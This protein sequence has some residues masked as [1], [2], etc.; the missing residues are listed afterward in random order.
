MAN[1]F[2]KLR[3]QS[4]SSIHPPWQT[5]QYVTYVLE[6]DEGGWVACALRLLGRAEDGVWIMSGDFKTPSG[7]ATVWFRCDPN[8]PSN[9]PD[10]VPVK[11]EKIRMSPVDTDDPR[12]LLQDPTLVFSVAMNMLLVR[13][14][15]AAL[16]CLKRPARAVSYPC[17]IDQVYPFI[18]EGP[19]YQKHHDLNPRVPLTGVACLSIDG[20]KNPMTVASFGICDPKTDVNSYE[21][22]VDLSHPTPVE[23]DGFSLTYPS[24]WFL[25]PRSEGQERDAGQPSYFL[26]AGGNSCM[27]TLSVSLERGSA[28]HIAHERANLRARHSTVAEGGMGRLLPRQEVHFELEGNAQGFISD[29]ENSGIAGFAY[30]G[31]YCAD[32]GDRLAHVNVFGCASKPNPRLATTLTAM[33]PAFRAILESF[34]FL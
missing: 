17:G 11:I 20:G 26:M 30:S 15:S 5:G 3:G 13:R 9:E 4:N 10:V 12:H 28:A 1:W 14:S 25:R 19:G 34:R 23:H 16:E 6:Y 8:A 29:L 24:T 33:E 21:D 7:E 32:S 2:Q 31:V 18:S 27:A 22:F